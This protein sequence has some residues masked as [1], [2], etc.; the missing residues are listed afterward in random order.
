MKLEQ[1]Y[2]HRGQVPQIPHD[3]QLRAVRLVEK[4]GSLQREADHQLGFSLYAI[5]ERHTLI[6]IGSS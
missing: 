4:L 2:Q 1:D 6:T 5:V 3:S